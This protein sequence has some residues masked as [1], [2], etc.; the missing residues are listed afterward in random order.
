MVLGDKMNI[1]ELKSIDISRLTI[2]STGIAVLF[3]VIVS[4]II[5]LGIVTTSANNIKVLLYLIPTIIV[6]T[7]MISIYSNFL[8][9]YLYNVLSK[10][11]NNIK[12]EFNDKN[13]ISKISTTS[14]ATIIA[15]IS[16]IYVILIYLASMFILPLMINSIMQTLLYSGQTMLAYSMYSVLL[17]VNN[18]LTVAYMILGTFII[19]F[20]FTLLGTYIYN[21]LAS[22][23]RGVLLTLSE[24][25][26]I[27]TIESISVLKLA[28]VFSIIYGILNVILA[29]IMI[30]S[31]G[32]TNIA[33]GTIIGGFVNGFIDSALVAIFYNFLAPRLGKLKIELINQ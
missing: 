31:G 15:I 30:I 10:R 12:I 18:P 2:I 33:I 23:G 24:E 21:I 20:V 32:A 3:S 8:I 26:G 27:T 7:F 17:I 13:E 9:G 22:K 6:T 25:N 14:T 4:I 29:I 1:K 16:T 28:I 11:L 19:T 5:M